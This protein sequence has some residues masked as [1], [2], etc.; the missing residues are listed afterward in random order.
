LL[1]RGLAEVGHE[2][3]YLLRNGWSL[4][5]P[6]GVHPVS[7]P[8]LDV[9]LYHS[10]F[11]PGVNEDVSR[12]LSS[13]GTPWLAT[14]ALD[15]SQ[16][17]PPSEPNWI[18]VSASL[19]RAHGRSRYVWNG[20]DPAD[21]FFATTKEDYFLFISAMDNYEKGLDTALELSERQGF[22]LVVAGSARKQGIIEEVS[23]RCR[24]ASAEYL[25]DVRGKRKAELIGQAK[26]LLFTSRLNEGCPL[27]IIEALM[28]GTPVISSAVGGCLEMITPDTGFLCRTVAEFSY[29]IENVHRI[30]P[31]RCRNAALK[32]FHYRKMTA[33]YLREYEAEIGQTRKIPGDALA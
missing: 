5:P 20:L 25:G 31:F 22:R 32:Y 24:A 13:H 15:H 19:A 17:G 30:D 16:I 6:P 14:C 26:A 23:R 12:L 9:D 1:A 18:F 33:E 8:I 10:V 4:Q 27:V 29:A 11:I 21:C 28:S 7:N 3:F 2:V